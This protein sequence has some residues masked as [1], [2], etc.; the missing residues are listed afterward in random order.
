MKKLRSKIVDINIKY[1]MA[2]HVLLAILTALFI[3]EIFPFAN[4]IKILAVSIFGSLI[5]DTDHLIYFYTYG[6]RTTYAQQAVAFI[7]KFD[8]RGFMNFVKNNHKLNHG[9]LSH[10]IGSFFLASLFFFVFTLDPDRFTAATFAMS[11]ML[12]FLYDIVEDFIFFG[13]LNPNWLFKFH[14]K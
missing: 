10:N 4:F 3:K 14:R 2:V 7:K 11:V 8:I 9:L 12:H 6:K 5:P 13:K 1:H